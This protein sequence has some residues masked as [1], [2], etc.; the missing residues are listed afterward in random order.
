MV[1]LLDLYAGSGSV[2]TVARKMGWEVIGIDNN[3][4]ASGASI[5]ADILKYNY[6]SLPVPDVIFSS[7]PCT[8]YS[9]AATWY[10]H[11]DP[12]TA[13]PLTDAAKIAD[14]ILRRTI[15]IYE[16]FRTK[17]PR[18][19]FIIENP[20]GYMRR[21]PEVQRFHRATTTHSSYGSPIVKPT[22]FWSNF[23]LKLKPLYFPAVVKIGK[24]DW[25]KKIGDL[26]G[27]T[28]HDKLG[29]IPSKLVSSILKQSNKP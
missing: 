18:L 26:K 17:N 3:P 4:H 20:R 13:V 14:R 27:K 2:G 25:F 16:H 8:T 22:D 15:K 11:R 5:Y 29:H 7:P 24:K 23:A 10:R 6:R 12:K 19:R 21:R 1:V 28:Q 9:T